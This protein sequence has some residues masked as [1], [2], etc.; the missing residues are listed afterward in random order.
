MN[1]VGLTTAHKVTNPL[2]QA[3]TT[4]FDPERGLALTA[5]DPNGIVT[6]AAVRRARPD[7]RVWLDSRATTSPANYNYSYTVSNTGITAVTTQ[8]LNDE[9]GYI[10]RRS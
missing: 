7:H 8:K 4:T 1:S 2:G 9:S 3:T 10:R 6:T 5:T